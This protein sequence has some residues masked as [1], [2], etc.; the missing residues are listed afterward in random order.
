ML[1]PFSAALRSHPDR[2]PSNSPE[3]AERT[4]KFQLIND[5]YYT[6]SDP[7]RRRDYDAGRKYRG[8]GSRASNASTSF[9]SDQGIPTPE[10]SESANTGTGA[11]GSFPWTPF[12][13]SSGQEN[14]G[15]HR[16]EFENEQFGDVFEEMLREEGMA[17][18]NGR[19]TGRFWSL[20][21]SLS[22]A[23]MG[24][25]I[26]NIPGMLAGAVAGNKLGSV[27]DAKGK[28]VYAVF[29]E[30]PSDAKMQLLGQLAAKVFSHAVR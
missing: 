17:E 15:E 14:G 25:I 22:G 19:P 13:K 24:Y 12:S 29:Q 11:W 16:R 9:D 28:S 2:V 1:I 18:D 10:S 21:G 20:V 27:R 5:A 23:A 7:T 6:L 8:F 30:L 26:A 4:R 3:R